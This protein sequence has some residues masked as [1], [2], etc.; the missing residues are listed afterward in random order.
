[1]KDSYPNEPAGAAPDERAIARKYGLREL[2]FPDSDQ[3]RALCQYLT[4]TV[5]SGR[6]GPVPKTAVLVMLEFLQGT[7]NRQYITKPPSMTKEEFD[8]LTSPY[9]LSA[10]II[11]KLAEKG[12]LYQTTYLTL[13][14]LIDLLRNILDPTCVWLH[15]REVPTPVLQAMEMLSAFAQSYPEARRQGRAV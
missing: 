14:E 11:S 10:R 1:M 5:Q 6:S 2:A 15:S 7:L 3:L 8:L 12:K 13:T 9:Y 4:E